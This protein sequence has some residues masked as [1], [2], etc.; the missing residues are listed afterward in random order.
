M[1]LKNIRIDGFKSFAD[2]T[3]FELKPGITAIVGPNGSGK[4]NIVDA[5]K[6]VLGEQSIKSLRGSNNMTDVIFSGTEKRD[7][8]NKASVTL[9]FDNSDHYL[10]SEFTE[11]EVKR[12]VYKSGDNEYFLNN[13]RV[14]LK[15]ITELFIDSGGGLDAFNIISQG[16]VTDVVNSKPNERRSIFESAAGVLKYKKR[17]EESLKKLEKTKENL[18]RIDLIIN[19][20]KDTIEPLKEQS[21][22]A[23]KYVELTKSLSDLEIG[24]SAYDIK[25]INDEYKIIK[26]RI[27]DINTK[28]ENF[29]NSVISTDI[30]NIKLDILKNDELINKLNKEILQLT[31]DIS[32]L[33]SE[34]NITIERQKYDFSYDERKKNLIVLKDEEGKI[35]KEMKVLTSLNEIKINNVNDLV[36]DLNNKN[37]EL[38]SLNI[39]KNNLVSELNNLSKEKLNKE[40]RID[41]IEKNIENNEKV[42]YAIKNI[43]NNPRL[44][45]IH[46]TINNLVSYNEEYSL[47][48]DTILQ[49]S[50]NFLI[51]D[52]ENSAKNA[53]NYL[54]DNKLGRAT[55]LPLNIIK[56]RFIEDSILIRLKQINGYIGIMSD[57]INYDNIYDNIIKNQLGNIIVVKDIDSMNLIGKILEYKYRIVS[58][59]GS[60]IHAGGSISGGLS[61]QSNMLNLKSELIK[62]KSDLTANLNRINN[63]NEEI[64]NINNDYNILYSQINEGNLSL[65]I[66]KSEIEYNQKNILNY[67][68]K[69]RTIKSEMKSIDDMNNNKLDNTLE[70]ILNKL[71]EEETKKEI[72]IAKQ[73]EYKNKKI[74]LNNK[75]NDL[76]KKFSESNSEYRTLQTE[77][78][79]NEVTLGKMDVKLDNLLL[80]LNEEYNMTYEYA[81]NNYELPIESDLART[82]VAKLKK[83]IKDLGEVNTGSIKEYERLNTRY[84]FL[85]NQKNDLEISIAN[86]LEIIKEMDEI[87]VE[88]F[89]TTFEKISK[90]FTNV[91]RLIF[92]GGKGELKLTMPEDYL[93]TG[94]E[95]IA[96][97]AG[98]KLN[99]TQ[100]L[101]GGEKSLTAICLL[102]A[103]LNV[104]TVPFIIL[105]EVEAALDEVNV[106]MFGEYL[107]TLKDNS[108]FILITHKKRMMEYADVLYG[109][110]MQEQGVSKI[111]GVKLENDLVTS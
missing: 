96:V 74:D 62:L 37:N 107:N 39:K 71:N 85:T 44:T 48:I 64:K 10:N 5:I 82:K 31:E 68:E 46:N 49:S 61:K 89:K 98:K 99:N 109:I 41:I 23:Q 76:E 47:A 83:E 24:L 40:N 91:F 8:M 11:I 97:P 59:D 58:L 35:K 1:Y 4:S 50:G 14:R 69:L 63:L 15:D 77:L 70:N 9:T 94:I 80:L 6:W 27:T 32:K 93:N 103:I 20:I 67:E 60:I 53:I 25:V 30:E 2:K 66:L 84:E 17:K 102:F 19:E 101:S 26:D 72:K 55:F 36:T 21:I 105:D 16:T 100:S 7:G 87:M 3:N 12:C 28:L 111:V 81:I 73:N 92:K 42:P 79:K 52:N 29:N 88:K 18:L 34:K 13:N 33:T 54:K 78:T 106:D 57:L 56:P 75:L 38:K 51:V 65:N 45:G 22:I 104:S 90:E 95:I 86:L 110:T 43:L 108:Q